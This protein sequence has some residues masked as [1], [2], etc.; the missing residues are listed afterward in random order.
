PTDDP[1][2]NRLRRRQMRN[3]LATLLLSQGTPMMV[4]GDEFARTQQGNNNAYC[5]D[6]DIS[7]VDWGL[8]EKNKSQVEFVRRLTS[9]RHK[10]PI[11]RR[12]LFMTGQCNEELGVKDLTWINANGHE[13]EHTNWGD[14]GMRC[15]GMLMDGRA[16]ATGIRQRG[17][18]A[19]LLLVIN[20]HFD[21][22]KFTLPECPGGDIWSLLIDTNME[23]ADEKS[24][25]KETFKSGDSYDVTARSV[26]LFA[27][28]ANGAGNPRK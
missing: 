21:L 7:W 26:L 5:Q 19:T 18:E 20:G 17:H 27:L 10:Y 11:L 12:N 23:T 22:V 3:M 1:E 13:M 6:N 16:Q 25:G 4:A 28:Q 14:D 8:R 9:L 24:G 15:F 2:I